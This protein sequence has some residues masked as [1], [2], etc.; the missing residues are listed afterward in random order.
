MNKKQKKEILEFYMSK[1]WEK[2]LPKPSSLTDWQLEIFGRTLAF[3]CWRLS[4]NW[5]HLIDSIKETFKKTK[6]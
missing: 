5:K 1:I 3:T 6:P 2:G 4:N